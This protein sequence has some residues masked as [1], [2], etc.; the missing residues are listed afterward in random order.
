MSTRGRS[1]ANLTMHGSLV[2]D[3]DSAY[4]LGSSSKKW[5]SLH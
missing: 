3:A 2:P 4:D 1:L 5:K